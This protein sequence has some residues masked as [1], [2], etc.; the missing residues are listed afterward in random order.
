MIDVKQI[1]AGAMVNESA[2]RVSIMTAPNILEML[3]KAYN[4]DG[5]VDIEGDMYKV[6]KLYAKVGATAKV[7]PHREYGIAVRLA[8]IQFNDRG[9][10]I[11]TS[12][13]MTPEGCKIS[14]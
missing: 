7:E 6:T 10:L 14:K 8:D 13:I 4:N 1:F 3:T 5:M 9:R 12:V 2:P 11:D